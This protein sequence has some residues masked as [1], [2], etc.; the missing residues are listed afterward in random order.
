MKVKV[1]KNKK[2]VTTFNVT[3]FELMINI[4]KAK[5]YENLVNEIVENTRVK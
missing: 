1:I 3:T 5:K 2:L 4:L